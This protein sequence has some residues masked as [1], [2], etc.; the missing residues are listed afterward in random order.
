M[1]NIIASLFLVGTICLVSCETK[2][3]AETSSDS[4]KADT[5]V[6]M[7]ESETMKS[8]D[9]VK[10]DSNMVKTDTVKTKTEKKTEVKSSETHKK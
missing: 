5:A 1:K 7:K 4:T 10:T 8:S 9:S 2:K 6:M 3:S